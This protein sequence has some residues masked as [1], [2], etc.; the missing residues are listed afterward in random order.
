MF[1]P[2]PVA[3]KEQLARRLVKLELPPHQEVFAAG[4][5]G[6][7]FYLV[8]EGSV[9]VLPVGQPASVA[10]PGDFFG[11]IA[12]LR[13]IPRTATVRTR[14]ECTL[15]ALA[16]EHFLTVVTGHDAGRAAGERVVAQRLGESAPAA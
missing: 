11:E 14:T 3:T 5:D 16:R 4:A 13:D 10:G 2:L 7:R 6:D 1:E 15:Y 12:L 8:A 9:D